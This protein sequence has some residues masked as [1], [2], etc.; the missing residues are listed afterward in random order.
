MP[1]SR[2]GSGQILDRD[3]LVALDSSPEAAL[4]VAGT[5]R[6]ATMMATVRCPGRPVDRRWSERS[7]HCPDDVIVATDVVPDDGRPI[8]ELVVGAFGVAVVH[9]IGPP[10]RSAAS[11]DRGRLGRR[12]GWAPTEHPLDRATRDAERVRRWLANGDLDFVSASTR[13]SSRPTRSI[14]RSAVCAVDHGRA[15]PRL[16]RRPAPPAQSL[17]AGRIQQ[18]QARVR[19]AVMDRRHDG[20]TGRGARTRTWN[21]RDISPPL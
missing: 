21:Q 2:A 15:D 6:L 12:D 7:S 4:L 5:D 10:T 3:G 14:P 20:A 13:R 9:E 1:G 19:D 8:P 18:V 16:D 11:G 17:S